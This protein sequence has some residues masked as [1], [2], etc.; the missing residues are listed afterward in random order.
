LSVACLLVGVT[1]CQGKKQEPAAQQD[2]AYVPLDQLEGDSATPTGAAPRPAHVWSGDDSATGAA[3]ESALTIQ[4]GTTGR[5]YTVQRGDTL[6]KLARRFY[7]DAAKWR[8]IYDA[9]RDVIKDPN[10]IEVGMKLV[11][12]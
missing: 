5:T 3:D 11:I 8:D 4:E 2:Q 1:A 7:N 9:N 6:Y 12:P 10:K